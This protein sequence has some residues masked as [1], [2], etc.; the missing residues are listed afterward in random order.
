MIVLKIKQLTKKLSA[1]FVLALLT[2]SFLFVPFFLKAQAEEYKNDQGDLIGTSDSRMA[3]T[4]VESSDHLEFQVTIIG[5]IFARA[6]F[7]AMVYDTTA[8]KLT[9]PTYTYDAPDGT[10]LNTL[11]YPVITMPDSFTDKHS[12]YITSAR[13]HFPVEDGPYSGMKMFCPNIG[14]T[15]PNATNVHLFPGEMV[16]LFSFYLRKVNPG[17]PLKTSDF[18][19]YAQP[20]AVPMQPIQSPSWMYGAFEVRYAPTQPWLNYVLKPEL[21]TYRS[22][23]SV[24]TEEP[25][26]VVENSATLNASFTR[27]NFQPTHNIAV[28]EYLQQY[29]THRL[30]WDDITKYG[31]IY[32]DV[33]AEIVV[34]GFSNKLNIDGEDYYFPNPAELAA[35]MFERNGKTFYTHQPNINYADD[36]TVSFNQNITGLSGG[37]IYYAWSFIH[38]SFETSNE[39]LNVGNKITFMTTDDCP[40]PYVEVANLTYCD[41]ENVPEYN[42]TGSDYTTFLWERVVGL[43]FGMP[44]NAGANTM[45]AFVA[46]NYGFEAISAIYK[47]TPVSD[48]GCTG[49]PKIFVITVN[50]TPITSVVDDMVYCNA[51][52]APRFDFTSNMPDAYFEWE[53]VNESGSTMIQGI[54]ASGENY[55]PAFLAYNTGNQPMVGKYRVRAS[56]VYANLPCYDNEWQYFNIVILPTPEIPSVTP[57][58]Q[59]ICSGNSLENIIFGGNVPQVTYKWTRIEG[60]ITEIPPIGEGN[61]TG[62]IIENNTQFPLEAIYE[63]VAV[64]NNEDYPGYSCTSLPTQFSILVQPGILTDPVQNFVYCNG[65]TT[66]VYT[67]TGNNASATYHWELLSGAS[68]PIPTS[69]VNYL[70]SFLAVNDGN[71]PLIANYRVRATYNDC[72]ETQWK[73]FSISILPTPTVASTPVHQTVC[74]GE[75]TLPVLFSSNVT[76]TTFHWTKVSGNIPALPFEGTGNFAAHTLENT[77]STVMEVVYEVTPM[78]NYMQYPDYTCA[79]TPTQFTISV[80]PQPK[81]NTIP[82]MV[83][84]EG[85]RAPNFEFGNFSGVSYAWQRISGVNVGLAENGTGQLPSFI[86]VNNNNSEIAEAIYE[87]TASYNMYG[88]VCTHS[89]TFTIIVNPT[90]SVELNIGPYEFCANVETP[91][92]DLTVEFLSL[93]NVEETV[94]EWTYISANEIG[95]PQTSG[96]NFIPSFVAINNGPQQITALFKVVAR[97]GHCYSEERIFKINVNPVPSIISATH[98]GAICS[99]NYFEYSILTSTPVN[100]ISWERLPH[101]DINNNT[102]AS[103]NGGYISERIYNTSASDINVTYKVSIQ[104]AE[105]GEVNIGEVYLIVKPEIE[106][107]INPLI[108]ACNNESTVAIQYDFELPGVQYTLIFDPAAVADGWISVKE[109]TTLPLSEILVNVPDGA[110]YGNYYATLNVRLGTCIT[111]S[112]IVFAL[113]S[114]PVLTN[115]SNA[116]IA[117]CNNEDLYLFVETNGNVQYQWYFDGELI[118]GETKSFYEAIF[119]ETIAGVYSVEISNECGTISY[120]FNVKTNAAMIEMKWDD[121]MYVDNSQNLYVAYQW[122]KDGNPIGKD[123]QSQ[124]YTEKGGFTP[125]AEYI[126]KAYKP[127]GTYDESCPFI[128][129]DGTTGNGGLIIYPNPTLRGNDVTFLLHF[130]NGESPES[131]VVIYDMNGKLVM[132]FEITDYKTEVRLNAA[133]GTYGVKVTTKNGTE[134]VEKLIIQ[135]Q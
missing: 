26:N 47:V 9:D 119:N 95:L 82:E 77:G 30:N 31:F 121:V 40:T 103:G 135:K 15:D 10:A 35:G 123:G 60:N 122:Y 73:T 116:D 75:T 54:P 21:F 81:I 20:P 34:N 101:P 90:P 57:Q 46:T 130:P 24:I 27:G 131:T 94:Y 108:T 76:N 70:P 118:P 126:V 8:L 11:G 112:D 64:L 68:L 49:E 50:P 41:G 37:V 106:L 25:T 58:N 102:G 65:E 55:I 63:V 71:T 18:G 7:F 38:Y 32:S 33:N 14:I 67:F 5:E 3:V 97:V 89:E 129:N 51:T 117:L 100:E 86:A 110:K 98:A 29:D 105:C 28:S 99:G 114:T 42:F 61:I 115:A 12:G 48:Y 132:Q 2:V 125:Y 80:L 1:N 104:S 36:Q 53:F 39:F 120:D 96:T 6:F 84:C 72:A 74:S 93:N 4:V 23:S 134:F 13:Q 92:I 44:Q 19:Y 62:M 85:E 45:P 59:E 16:H 111:S 88:T 109:F 22:P 91:I 69:G 43:D 124:Y 128:P 113:G 83:Y 87:V 56:Y 66:S 107:N 79:G 17:T 127:D 52:D 78:L 133:S